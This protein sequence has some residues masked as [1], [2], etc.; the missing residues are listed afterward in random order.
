MQNARVKRI[1]S[2]HREFILVQVLQGHVSDS[3]MYIY[4]Y[5]CIYMVFHT[6]Y[7]YNTDF[8]ST[9]STQKHSPSK[10]IV[11]DFT[12]DAGPGGSRQLLA[13]HFTFDPAQ[14]ARIQLGIK[15]EKFQHVKR[16]CAK[17]LCQ[18]SQIFFMFW[19]KKTRCF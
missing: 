7:E 6:I 14:G 13:S 2:I 15:V 19:R 8:S 11:N 17:Q 18:D 16:R 10:F 3:Y 4:I 12:Q 9:E 5:I 1:V